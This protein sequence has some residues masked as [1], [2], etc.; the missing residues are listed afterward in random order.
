MQAGYIFRLHEHLWI[1]WASCYSQS[2]SFCLGIRYGSDSFICPECMYWLCGSCSHA[3]AAV[4]NKTFVR[5]K[6][7][8]Y[9]DIKDDSFAEA[10]CRGCHRDGGPRMECDSRRC[11]YALCLA[12][13]HSVPGLEKFFAEHATRHARMR[14]IF[15]GPIKLMAVYPDFWSVTDRRAVEPCPCLTPARRRQF[16]HCERCH[17]PYAIFSS[18]R[19]ASIT[20]G[21]PFPA[22]PLRRDRADCLLAP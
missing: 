10:E 6:L 18:L 19:L 11:G 9:G 3:H 13:F 15:P 2:F 12:C 16:S 21:V 8:E 22:Y 4:H 14:Q 1:I 5:T 7:I 20:V 17:L